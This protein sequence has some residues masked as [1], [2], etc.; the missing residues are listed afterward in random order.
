MVPEELYIPFAD[1]RMLP[2]AAFVDLLATTLQVQRVVVGENY[3]FG[4][5]A[6]GD[7]NVLREECARHNVEVGTMQPPQQ[8][9]YAHTFTKHTR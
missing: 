8:P 1:V 4:F 6:A 3:R 2:P 5:K 9:P 7:A